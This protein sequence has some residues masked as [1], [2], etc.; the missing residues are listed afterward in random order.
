[1]RKILLLVVAVS[2]ALLGCDEKKAAPAAAAAPAAVAAA[3]AAPAAPAAKP[4]PAMAW[5]KLEKLGL[6]IEFPADGEVMDTSADAPNASIFNN[7]CK[8]SVNTVTPV[9][10]E[11]YESA[12]AEL[13]KDPG[14]KFE[15]WTKKTKTAD[16]WQLEWTCKSLLRGQDALRHPGSPHRGRQADRV[17]R[18]AGLGRRRRVRHQGVRQPQAVARPPELRVAPGPCDRRSQ[19]P[20]VARAVHPVHS[21]DPVHSVHPASRAL[22]LRSDRRQRWQRE[23]HAEAKTLL[24]LPERRG[25]P[26]IRRAPRCDLAR[27]SLAFEADL[28][29]RPWPA[30]TCDDQTVRSPASA[31]GR[32]CSTAP[33]SPSGKRTSRTCAGGSTSCG[34]PGSRTSKGTAPGIRRSCLASPP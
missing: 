10:T 2:F 29:P 8:V 17:L 3:P 16:G 30:T 28:R 24:R 14:T 9:Y 27:A 23:V 25:S 20:R 18:E 12:I 1:M 34:R 33:R 31:D 32:P 19:G 5:K 6:Q 26:Q 15:K 4:A 22:R 21:V 7:D 11:K 13:E